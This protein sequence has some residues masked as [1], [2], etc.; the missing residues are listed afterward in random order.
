[1]TLITPGAGWSITSTTTVSSTGVTG[2]LPFPAIFFTGARL[3]LALATVRLVAFARADLRALP[4]LAEFALRGFARFRPIRRAG[5]HTV[6]AGRPCATPNHQ[7][8]CQC[9]AHFRGSAP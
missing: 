3:G 4:R 9:R 7:L 5:A 1:V 8:S 2:A 6:R